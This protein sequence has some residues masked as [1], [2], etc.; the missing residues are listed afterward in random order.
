MKSEVNVDSMLPMPSTDHI[1]MDYDNICETHQNNALH[2]KQLSVCNS[3]N[4]SFQKCML[5]N[6]FKI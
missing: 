3:G 5:L 6:V 1:D 2:C 4:F